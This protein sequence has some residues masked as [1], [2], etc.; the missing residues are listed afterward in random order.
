MKN[1]VVYYDR[2]LDKVGAIEDD[3]SGRAEHN[4]RDLGWKLLGTPLA[5]TETDAIHYMTQILT[6]EEIKK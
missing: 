5:K 4:I 1:W 6:E 2:D 3:H